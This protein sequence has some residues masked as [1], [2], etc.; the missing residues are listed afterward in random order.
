MDPLIDFKTSLILFSKCFPTGHLKRKLIISALLLQGFAAFP[1]V[2]VHTDF[3]DN[4]SAM[5]IV[6][7]DKGLLIPRVSLTTDLTDPSPVT[8]PAVGLLVFNSGTDQPLGFYYWDGIHWVLIGS[9]SSGGDYWSLYGNS[10]TQVGD[11]FI[12][13]TDAQ[14]FAVYTNALERLRITSTGKIVAGRTAPYHAN[15]LFTVVG[16]GSL[17]TAYSAFTPNTGFYA[18][19]NSVG[20][21]N[22]RGK[23][24]VL[25]KV[26]SSS[27]YAVYAKNYD[28]GGYGM[29]ALG[30]NFLGA[31][32][33]NHISGTVSVGGDGVFCWGKNP[34][35]TGIIAVGSNID[36]A[37]SHPLGSGG[38]FAGYHGVFARARNASGTGV[39]GGGNNINP[40]ALGAGSGGAFTGSSSG[41]VAWATAATSTGV[42]GCGNNQAVL[43]ISTGSGGAFI[44]YHGVFGKGVNGAGI[45]VIGLGSNGINFA[46]PPA[47]GCGGAFTGYY[48]AYG[49]GAN[50]AA[51]IG[52]IGLGNNIATP[53]LYATGAG[54]SFTGL[55][56]GAVGYG[57][58]AT[59]GVGVIGAGNNVATTIPASGGC[60]GAFT[61]YTCGVYGYATNS[62]NNTIRY[63]GYFAAAGNTSNVGYA[64]VGG[65]AVADNGTTYQSKIVGRGSV[66][67][68]VK[69]REGKLIALT[70]PEAPEMVFQ[71][72]GTGKLVDGKAYITIDPN[73]A[74]NINVS[75][76]HPLK[77]YITP[78][79]DCNGVYVTNKSA[80]GFE[81]IEL[82]GGKSNIDFSWQIVATRANEIDV[83]TDGTVEISD[84]TSRFPPAPGPLEITEQPAQTLQPGTGAVEQ[85][86]VKG[87]ETI[88]GSEATPVEIIKDPGE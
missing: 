79:G 40:N 21:Y 51:G 34:N 31:A 60:G 59:N 1:Q 37:Y 3:P 9:G 85:P 68:I 30:A 74:L 33:A 39:I 11:N 88:Q 49:V 13:T 80:Q 29:M 28:P 23:Y 54:G 16:T 50:I 70:C 56:A 42:T 32:L 87:A 77:V 7:S 41:L 45:G 22:T 63:G 58:D 44:G 73:L 4:S 24:G 47:N 38:A 64:Y 17:D 78:E 19:A 72:F 84:Y 25:T 48:G 6:A 86:E 35:G 82:Q 75:E 8:S 46:Q 62:T 2:G 57:T 67:T 5:D 18:R 69:N 65:R 76:A 27:G 12:G 26:D 36:T 81:V 66:Q 53:N 14:D 20:F 43:T 71:D 15:D 52:V 61:G 83:L 10:D 55:N